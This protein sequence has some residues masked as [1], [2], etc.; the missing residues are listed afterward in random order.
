MTQ[1]SHKPSV[2]CILFKIPF[3]AVTFVFVMSAVVFANNDEDI[4]KSV[5]KVYVTSNSIDFLK[6]WQSTGSRSSSGSGCVIEG[7]RIITNAHVVEDSTFIQVRKET[8][9]KKYTA[10]LV[11]FGHDCDLAVLTVDDHEFFNDIKA[12]EF[13]SL[14]ELRDSVI[15]MGFPQGG[16]KLSMTEGVV[17]RIEVIHY[18]QSSKQLLGVQI[19]A[20][21]NPGNSGGPV[22]RAGKVVGIAMQMMTSSQNIGY[23]IPVPIIQHFLKDFEDG[24]YDGF[25]TLG[26]EY[27]TTENAS[28][29]EYYGVNQSDSGILISN[30]LPYSPVDQILQRH[31]VMVAVDGVPI[32]EDG[33]YEFRKNERLSFS[34][35]TNSKQAKDKIRLKILRNREEKDVDII[36]NS[37]DP[38]VPRAN[39]VKKPSYYIYGGLVFTTLT[40]DLIRSWGDKWWQRAPFDF[41]YFL[42]GEGRLNTERRKEVVVLLDVLPDDTNS[43][44]LDFNHQVIISVNGK[45][46]SSFNEFVLILEKENDNYVVFET[47]DNYQIVISRKNIDEI[48]D[49]ILKRNN[50][51]QRYSDDIRDLLVF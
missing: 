11:A 49:K 27:H 7:N 46:F 15:V 5:V 26:I 22:V 31:D 43:G 12:V 3:L 18:A 34:F 23:M 37:M 4:R 21:I 35:L 29:R 30:V 50:I 40:T 47:L 9:P 42:I 36:L 41:L 20:A 45:K 39:T 33:T 14:P 32:A 17:S 16:D 24:V 28:L 38:L 25:P 19:D 1:K 51:A 48:T 8:S 2:R 13:G 44:Y 10:R 6:P